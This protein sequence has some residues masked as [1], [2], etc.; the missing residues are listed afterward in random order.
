ME[1]AL[2]WDEPLSL[3]ISKKVTNWLKGVETLSSFQVPGF[4]QCPEKVFEV[5][6]H[7]FNDASE[8]A[9]GSV[10]YQRPI[11]RSGK[12]ST[13]L[14][15]SK[16]KVAPLQATTIPRLELLSNVLGLR[17]AKT[18][19][20]AFQLCMD[21]VAFWC[22]S[23]NVL[24]WIRGRSRRF[25]PFVANRISEIQSITRP[26]MWKHI[27]TKINPADLVSRGTTVDVLSSN[28]LWLNGPSFLQKPMNEW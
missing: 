6:F 28:D 13:N 17:L 23:T 3:N 10:I 8:K 22:N 9:Y 14:V 15:M 2:D 19:V 4:L 26:M 18:F 24:W 25:K 11:Y 12:I 21:G 1:T 16:S 27:P 5:T 20:N 7:V